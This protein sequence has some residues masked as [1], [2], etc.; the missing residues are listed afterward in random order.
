MII[1]ETVEQVVSGSFANKLDQPIFK[2]GEWQYTRRQMVEVLQCANFIAAARLAKVLKRLGV[3]S[4]AQ[5]NKLD[6]YS[7]ARTKGIGESSIF[8]AMCIL[9]AGGYDVLKWWAYKE[10]VV[11]FATFKHH[12]I[13]RATKRKHEVA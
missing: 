5:L 11:R 1:R 7:L 13:N 9:D 2:V 12:A 4:A 10:N 8:V 3:Q 6:P